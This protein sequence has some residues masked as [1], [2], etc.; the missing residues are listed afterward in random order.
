MKWFNSEVL[1]VDET[2][3]KVQITTFKASLKSNEFVVVLAKSPPES[4]TE[5]LLKA[6]KYMNAEDALAVIKVGNA[7]RDRRDVQEDSKGKKRER[8][9][10]SSNQDN[11]KPRNDKTK[12]MVNSMPLLMLVDK[13]LMQIKDDH[14]LKWSKPLNS[15]PNVHNKKK[16][17]DFHR[18]H[19]HYT[20]ECKHLKEHI[21]EL[22]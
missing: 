4:M 3:D 21:E 1:E 2:K 11:I 10:Y 6:Q 15:S 8:K 19:R 18:D 5:L 17:Y 13:I 20:D 7:W 9:D 16:Y 14:P 12:R 22:I